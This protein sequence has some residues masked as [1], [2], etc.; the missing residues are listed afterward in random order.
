MMDTGTIRCLQ[1]YLFLVSIPTTK[2]SLGDTRTTSGDDHFSVLSK[3]KRF[4]QNHTSFLRSSGHLTSEDESSR[5]SQF[6]RPSSQL[7]MP[8]LSP[9]VSASNDTKARAAV[10][11]DTLYALRIPSSEPCRSS[12]Y[13]SPGSALYRTF[14]RFFNQDIAYCN[15]DLYRS[16]LRF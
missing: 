16:R 7:T 14:L 4:T 8:L 1:Y 5:H 3:C 11:C 6:S 15:S 12:S 13:Q 2:V 10:L 9:F